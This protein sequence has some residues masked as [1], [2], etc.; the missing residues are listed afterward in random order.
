MAADVTVEIFEDAQRQN[1]WRISH[2]S[3]YNH[4]V[5]SLLLVGSLFAYWLLPGYSKHLR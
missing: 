1:Q 3:L 5:E 2:E 4:Y